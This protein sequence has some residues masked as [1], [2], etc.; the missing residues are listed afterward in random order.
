MSRVLPTVIAIMMALAIFLAPQAAQAK[1]VADK[2]FNDS[3]VFYFWDQWRSPAGL[4][5]GGFWLTFVKY[6]S[7]DNSEKYW[8]RADVFRSD[9]PKQYGRI[10]ADDKIFTIEY[11]DPV[12]GLYSRVGTNSRIIPALAGKQAFYTLSTEVVNAILN[13]NN[14]DVIFDYQNRDN[15]KLN[16]SPARLKEFQQLV[17]LK[18]ADYDTYTNK[19]AVNR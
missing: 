15:I 6:I 2:E 10:V 3:V 11:I 16:L 17:A 8:I 13:A 7:N 5:T 14:V 12:P 4:G 18:P 9:Q 19:P 1:I